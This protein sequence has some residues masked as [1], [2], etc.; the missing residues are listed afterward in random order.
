MFAAVLSVASA[1]SQVQMELGIGG[2]VVVGAW[3]PLRV[4]ARDL[5]VGSRLE[6]TFDAR[7][8]PGAQIEQREGAVSLLMPGE[9]EL[10]V[11]FTTKVRP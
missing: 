3:N 9:P 11:R 4:V 10:T 7:V 8:E 6:V 5:P 1:Q 2:N